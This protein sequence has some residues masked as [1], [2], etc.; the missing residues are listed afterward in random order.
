MGTG[1]FIR[2]LTLAR[3]WQAAGGEAVL[4]TATT[5]APLI[6]R[7]REAGVPA[8]FIDPV[9]AGAGLE[10][11]VAWSG[12]HPGAWVCLDGYQFSEAYQ[13]ALLGAGA[14]LLVIDDYARLS[15]Y[16]ADLLLDQNLGAEER[17]YPL[18]TGAATLLG[19]RYALVAPEFTDRRVPQR[20]QPPVARRVL[21]TL[22]GADPAGQ[23]MKV[24][25]ALI[26]IEDPRLEVMCVVG[27]ANPKADEIERMAASRPGS[28]VVLDARNMPDLMAW[29]DIAVSGAGTTSWEL[30]MM[31]VPA[32]TIVLAENQR[33]AAEALAGAGIVLDL[34]W[35]EKVNSDTIAGAIV[36][37]SGDRPRR[38]EMARRGQELV[39]GL[40]AGR[41]VQEMMV[42]SE[43][44]G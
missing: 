15:W 7:V 4:F 21:L 22:G 13:T 32:V 1:H 3:A 39:D 23:T 17:V 36:K 16:H 33:P 12:D 31:G 9:A 2:S 26:G 18:K 27:A 41:V 38:Q 30:C 43:R 44:G 42:F 19:P 29:A 6:E 34:G 40:G 5:G 11:V 14:R 37:L 10:A 24:L 25:R 35:Y 20:P 28:K 8:T